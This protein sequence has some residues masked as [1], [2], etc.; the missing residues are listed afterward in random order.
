[1]DD[2]PEDAFYNKGT[3]DEVYEAAEQMKSSH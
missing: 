1:M 2:I 3:I